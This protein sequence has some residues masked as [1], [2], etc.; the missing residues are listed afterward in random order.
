MGRTAASLPPQGSNCEGLQ[1]PLQWETRW[2]LICS[3]YGFIAMFLGPLSRRHLRTRTTDKESQVSSVCHLHLMLPISSSSVDQTP[4]RASQRKQFSE[5]L[6][7]QHGA[8]QRAGRGKAARKLTAP[9]RLGMPGTVRLL[10]D[11]FR[12]SRGDLAKQQGVN[13]HRTLGK[14][15][16]TW[17]PGRHP[18]HSG[19]REMGQL[20]PSEGVPVIPRPQETV[21]L[22]LKI[23]RPQPGPG[24]C[25]F[26]GHPCMLSDAP[27]SQP[28]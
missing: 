3:N 22:A 19:Q 16:D 13:L 11:G 28:P 18:G 15:H 9:E 27:A 1:H 4:R 8:R 24:W 2:H 26:R 20:S 12:D 6:T 10:L 5:I 23:N 14:E 17:G 25:W 7:R 21:Q